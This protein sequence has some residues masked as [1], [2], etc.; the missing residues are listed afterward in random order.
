MRALLEELEADNHVGR[1]ALALV[2]HKKTFAL[3]GLCR[4]RT[5]PAVINQRPSRAFMAS[6]QGRRISTIPERQPL[7]PT[8]S[9]TRIFKATKRVYRVGA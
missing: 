5:R 8:T 3:P 2:R 6:A 1:P 9:I 4:T 7:L